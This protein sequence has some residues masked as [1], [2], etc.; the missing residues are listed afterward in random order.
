M[1]CHYKFLENMSTSNTLK[2]F[3]RQIDQLDDQ[4]IT[5]IAKRFRVTQKVGLYKAKNN[6]PSTDIEREHDQY[7]RINKVALACRLEPYIAHA[8]LTL[9]ISLATKNHKRLASTHKRL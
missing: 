5:L 1:G 2:I 4:I 7:E 3:R 9:L 6:L 8:V